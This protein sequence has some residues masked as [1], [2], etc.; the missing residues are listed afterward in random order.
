MFNNIMLKVAAVN[1]TLVVSGESVPLHSHHVDRLKGCEP[2]GRSEPLRAPGEA[3]AA[4]RGSGGAPRAP[5]LSGPGRCP[6][7][8][9][10]ERRAAPAVDLPGHTLPGEVLHGLLR[11][12][13]PQ[14]GSLRLLPAQGGQECGHEQ[15]GRGAPAGAAQTPGWRGPCGTRR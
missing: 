2:L 9:G 13:A 14:P 6:D 11:L 8:A 4:R 5:Q 1:Q 12:R 7:E 15:A 3:A 10:F